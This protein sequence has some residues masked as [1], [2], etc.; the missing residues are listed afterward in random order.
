MNE[1][2][3]T[4]G[5]RLDWTASAL[6]LYSCQL[7]LPFFCTCRQNYLFLYDYRLTILI[8][9]FILVLFWVLFTILPYHQQSLFVCPVWSL[10]PIKSKNFNYSRI[11]SDQAISNW[12][13]KLNF[14]CTQTR[15]VFLL[16]SIITWNAHKNSICA[17]NMCI[18]IKKKRR[19]PR[20]YI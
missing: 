17:G 3:L 6:V 7:Y 1:T 13:I 15:S 12:A 19:V 10:A 14:P 4:F 8:R 5:K 2:R 20:L 16:V 9:I 18:L 11:S